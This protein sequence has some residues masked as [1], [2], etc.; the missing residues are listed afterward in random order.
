MRTFVFCCL[1][2]CGSTGLFGQA[3]PYSLA[4]CAVNVDGVTTFLNRGGAPPPGVS[5]VGFNA[6]TGLGLITVAVHGQGS[7]Y[8]SVFVDHEIRD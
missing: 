7:H 3:A 2:M 8:V 6:E 1:V 4:D 5:L